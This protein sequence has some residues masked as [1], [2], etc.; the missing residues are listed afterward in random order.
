MNDL[1]EVRGIEPTSKLPERLALSYKSK[2]D[3]VWPLH[4]VLSTEGFSSLTKIFA[5]MKRT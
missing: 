4:R 3:V 1:H 2:G 5:A